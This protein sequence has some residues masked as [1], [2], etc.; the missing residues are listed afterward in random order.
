[1]A[2]RLPGGGDI[3]S[4]ALKSTALLDLVLGRWGWPRPGLQNLKDAQAGAKDI[5]ASKVIL[6]LP[7]INHFEFSGS[8]AAE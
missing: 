1:M 7:K 6:F 2:G 5:M 4:A 3:G 8:R